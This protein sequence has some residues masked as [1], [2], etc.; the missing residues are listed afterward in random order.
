MARMKTPPPASQDSIADAQARFHALVLPHLDRLLGFARRRTD[1]TSDAEDAVQEACIKAWLAFGDLR[2][3]S[4]VRPWLYR[5][6]RSVLSDSFE[7]SGRRRQ[8]V[9]ISRLEDTH[10]DLVATESDFVFSE[11]AARLDGEALREGLASI[12]EDFAT[13]VELHDID[14]FKYAEIAEIVGAPIGTVMSRISR[15]RRLLAGA[16]ANN[17]PAWAKGV[18]QVQSEL[19]TRN[20]RARDRGI[21]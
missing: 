9:S 3:E 11:V 2:D 6:L 14:G 1:D 5:I 10:E 18:A 4:L 13:A 16:L 20:N 8:L 21:S 7:K 17:R 15:G 19:P 12:P